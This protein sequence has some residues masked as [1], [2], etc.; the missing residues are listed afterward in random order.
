MGTHINRLSNRACKIGTGIEGQIRNSVFGCSTGKI[1]EFVYITATLKTKMFKSLKR[2]IFRKNRYNCLFC[3]KHHIV[4]V[5]TFIH[6]K[7]DLVRFA[8]DL[9]HRVDDGTVQFTV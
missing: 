5:G 8:G 7:A 2:G 9:G 6:G 4:G 1:L 3:S